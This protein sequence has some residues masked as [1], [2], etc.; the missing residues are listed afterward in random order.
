MKKNLLLFAFLMAFLGAVHAQTRQVTGKVTDKVTHDPIPGVSITVKGTQ[1][2]VS[3]NEKGIYKINVPATGT[4]ILVARYIGYKPNEITLT[5]QSPANFSMEDDVNSLSEVV[6]NIGYGTAKREALTGSVSSI[7][8]KQ[9]RDV[10]VSTAAEALAGRLAGVQVTTTEGKPGAEIQVR[11]RGGGSLTQDNTPLYIVDGIQ[12]ENALSLLSPQE[13]QS[14]DVLKD[15]ASTAIYGARGANGVVLITTKGGKDMKTQI[16]YTGYAGVRQIVNELE[17]MKPYDYVI[18]QYERSNPSQVNRDSFTKRYGN[19]NDLDIYKNMPFTNWQ[20]KVFGRSALSQTHILSMTGGTKTTTFNFTLNNAKED[21]I[22]LNSGFERTLASFKFDHK[23]NEKLRTGFNVRYSRQRIDGAGTSSTGSQ[24]TNRLRNA[25]RYQPYIAIGQEAAVDIFDPD[26]NQLTNLTSPVLLANSELKNDYRNDVNLN[27]YFSYDF[28]KNLTFRS[29]FGITSTN[30]R[31]N[32]F[33]GVPTGLAQQNAKMPVA[34]IGTGETLSLT[35]S[36]VL[37][38]KTTLA[39]DHALDMLIGQEI[40][41]LK[42]KSFGSTIKYLPVDI[43]AKEA[44]AGIQKAT[45]PTGLIQDAPTS[46]EGTPNRL[47]SFFGRAN[48]AYQ[49]KY[50]GTFTIRRDGSTRFSPENQ[51]AVFPSAAVAWR[52]SE[53]KFIK[54]YEWVS[55]LKLRFS[56]GLSGNNRI[57]EDLYKT[58]FGAS[59]KDGYAFDE[60]ITPGFIPNALARSDL[61]WETTISR[62]LGLDFALFNNRL[63]A[64]VDVYMNHTKDLLLNANIPSTTGYST[65]IQNIGK[66]QNKGIELQLSGVI[67]DKKDFSWNANFN[68][69]LNRNKIVSLGLDPSGQPKKSYAVASGWVNNLQDFFVEVGKPIGQFY[70]YVADGFYGVDDFNYDA[71]AKTYTLKPDVPNSSQA[72]LGSKV[73][74][75]GD[76][77]IKKLSNSSSMMIGTDDK[78]VLGNAQ[79]KFAGGLNQQFTFRNFDMSIYLN[80]SVGNKIYNANKSEFTTTYT[81][82]DNNLL[83][84]MNDRWKSFDANGIKVTDPDQLRAMNVNTKLWTPSL[85]EY[86]LTSFAIEDASFLRVSNITL[87]YSIPEKILRKTKVFSRFRVYATVNNLWTITG[88]SGYDPEASTRRSSPLTPGVDYAAY[89]RSRFILAG[90]NVTF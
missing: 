78:T 61:K 85:G 12:V 1:T 60:S 73:P 37:T 31:S 62:N 47:L 6:V 70:G 80:Y 32:A 66:T 30:S 40:Y 87:G 29:T 4:I 26:Y 28:L 5:S 18:Y 86:T 59:S 50:L 76:Q 14:I 67:I 48:Y 56:Y 8:E 17:V 52:I 68:I 20:D 16:S 3:T 58:T 11:V 43:T 55:N 10:P 71:A 89:P 25:V 34:V 33:N 77:K 75:P 42:G 27:G 90:L 64:T 45:P 57:G 72:V 21:G 46:S 44:Y 41:Q 19:W 63:N 35:N 74:Q 15:A 53:E 22:M 13:I 69:S 9:L 36:N 7:D 88:Y 65:Q 2:V 51:Y 81:T 54:Q 38:Y 39:K 49:G 24:G 83:A 23:V 79:P 82:Q 84:I